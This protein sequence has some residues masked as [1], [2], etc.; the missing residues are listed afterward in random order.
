M[1]QVSNSESLTWSPKSIATAT[2]RFGHLCPPERGS[3]ILSMGT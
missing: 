1:I 3:K 2:H